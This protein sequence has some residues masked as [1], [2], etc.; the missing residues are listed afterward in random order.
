MTLKA[1]L[2]D[3]DGTLLDY[4]VMQ[5]LM[6]PYF[7]L[8]TTRAADLV[9]P[10]KLVD[11]INQGSA[12]IARND[13]TRTNE[14]VFA[15]TFYPLVGIPRAVLEPVL[16]DFYTH[17]FP[18]L[19]AYAPARAKS[20]ATVQAAFDT[21]C[22]VVIA[23]NPFFPAIATR[24]RLRW[25][26]VD[27][28]QFNKVT[29]YENSRAAKPDLRYYLEILNDLRC[30]P[31][32]ALMVGDEA[33]DMAAGALGCRTFLVPSPATKKDTITCQPTYEGT[34]ETLIALLQSSAL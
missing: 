28:F 3:L 17:D 25:A 31:E 6:P 30:Q 4:D 23:T 11:A 33:W 16:I 27:D 32:E 9:P 13:G 12:A 10:H 18:K 26:A 8:L 7:K 34:L 5:D 21:G 22:D 20:R 19:K 24:E 1:I 2:F 14:E 15:A 29:T